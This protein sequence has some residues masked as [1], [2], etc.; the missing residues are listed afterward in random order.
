MKEI[1]FKNY[2]IVNKLGEGGMATVYLAKHKL[3]GN[4]VAIKILNNE[5]LNNSNIKNRFISE[6][7]KLSQLDHPNIVR[8]ID[9]L[10]SEDQMAFVME[11][12]KGK[13]LKDTLFQKKLNDAEI[14]DLLVQ[15]VSALEYIHSRGLIHRD[16]K[17]S[18]FIFNEYGKLKLTDFGIS[19]DTSAQNSEYTQ[20]ATHINMGTPMYM[21]PE[22]IRSLKGVTKLSDIYSL[23]V[24]L[25]EMASGKKPYNTQT[26]SSFEL[27]TKIVNDNLPLT[28]TKW[29]GVIQKAT[30]KKE[31]NRINDV[32]SFLN[33]IAVELK[34]ETDRTVVYNHVD[35]TMHSSSQHDLLKKKK[36]K[37]YVIFALGLI[38]A[39]VT[40]LFIF[41]NKG[42]SSTT[43]TEEASITAEEVPKQTDDLKENKKSSI[44]D[45]DFK[46]GTESQIK[47]KEPI[48]DERTD[49]IDNDIVRINY[50]NPINGYNVS[51]L[52]TPD[53]VISTYA[54][55]PATL[56]FKN[57]KESFTITNNA[58]SLPSESF[59]FTLEDGYSVMAVSP[60]KITLDYQAPYLQN[61]IFHEI[62][63]PFFFLDIN[64]DGNKELLITKKREGQRY[65]D[66]FDVYSFD[67]N[68]YLQ[69]PLAQITNKEPYNRFDGATKLDRERKELIFYSSGGWCNYS[70]KTYGLRNGKLSLTKIVKREQL[71][72]DQDCFE[73]VYSVKNGE[74]QLLSQSK[75][76]EN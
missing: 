52:W 24:V 65:Y 4:E 34:A 61:I 46:S 29:D 25:W 14:E 37:Q 57:K 70:H 19:K 51:V 11:Y 59:N 53:H 21:S 17:P 43:D 5:F 16:I 30:E 28:H 55:G 48:L 49:I 50:K 69:P 76:D 10:E 62:D 40:G 33:P 60:N 36:K 41:L 45:K 56:Y 64:F 31:E 44:K 66:S 2:S 18:N 35:D 47:S 58:F 1:S 72:N 23:G 32:N 71:N 20:T 22:Q 67:S 6:A 15:M 39:L 75:I 38:I 3:L 63:K 26:L 12:L 74:S 54:I 9:L 13:S 42:S 8:V 27:Q 73:S 7:Q 68:G